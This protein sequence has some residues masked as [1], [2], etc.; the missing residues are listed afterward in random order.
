VDEALAKLSGD[1]KAGAN[2]MPAVINAVKV[3]ATVG[4]IT[5]CLVDVYGRFKEPIRF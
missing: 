1:A 3:Y 5:D 2:V 4:E